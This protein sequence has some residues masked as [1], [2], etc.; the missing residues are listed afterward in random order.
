MELSVH[1]L[2]TGLN[3][4]SESKTESAKERKAIFKLM[5]LGDGGVGKTT[6]INRFVC[7]SYIPSQ[8]TIGTG[9]AIKD[10]ALDG[11][12]ITLSIWD[13]AGEER[14][15]FLVPRFCEGSHGC[16][17]AFDSARPRTFFNLEEWLELVRKHTND[18][19]VIL[20]GTKCDIACFDDELAKELVNKHNLVSYNASSAKDDIGITEIFQLITRAMWNKITEKRTKCDTTSKAQ[21][22]FSFF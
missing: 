4:G 20:V 9:F 22:R 18:I 17:L 7:G 12:R 3:G 16:I 8:M 6:M 10:V 2:V 13:F 5:L 21:E 15:R 14:F 1:S 19:P 11:E